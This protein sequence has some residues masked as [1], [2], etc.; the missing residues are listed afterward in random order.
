MPPSSGENLP[1]YRAVQLVFAAHLRD[2]SCNPPPSDVEPRR[3]QIY[4][5][6]IYNN[7]ER[8]LANTFRI[9]RSIS[10]DEA[11]H[12]MVRDFLKRHRAASPYF[13]EIP[14]E[15]IA[16]L[17]GVRD[18]SADPPW[19]LELA[20]YEWVELALDLDTG[21]I[22]SVNMAIDG[23]LM[24]GSPVLSP[25]AWLVS[26]QY[27]VHRL[28]ARHH[29]NDLPAQPTYLI[30]YRDRSDRVRFLEA[31]RVTARL[32]SILQAEPGITGQL[33]IEMIADELG[34]HDRDA[35]VRGGRQTLEQLRD[36][37]IIAGVKGH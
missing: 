34:G 24:D 2:P 16:Y 17:E 13:Q 36:C 20:H 15:F 6:L 32:Y 14:L 1:G 26:Y 10:S 12:A 25:L 35:V 9:I 3:M 11:W 31:N 18:C 8:F 27:P 28:S 29:S 30:V 22:P 19:L 23:D 4:V 7:V 33:A 21:E 5:D 37:A